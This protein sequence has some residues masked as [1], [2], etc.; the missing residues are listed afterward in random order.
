MVENKNF[1]PGSYYRLF[2]YGLKDVNCTWCNYCIASTVAD[3]IGLI[4]HD[5]R[6]QSIIM[7]TSIDG[8]SVKEKFFIDQLF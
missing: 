6:Y 4:I 1:L 3:D 7:D 8:E 5:C 2:I